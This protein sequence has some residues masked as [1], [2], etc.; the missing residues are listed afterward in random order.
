M[1]SMIWFVLCTEIKDQTRT[2]QGPGQNT[3]RRAKV[4][5]NLMCEGDVGD[6]GGDMGGVVLHR[7]DAGV[8]RLLL[9]IRV[10]LTLL[11]DT[12]GAP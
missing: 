11:T 3:H 10:Q 6:L 9:P 12:S 5:S 4:V 1:C 7:D 2:R 8:Q